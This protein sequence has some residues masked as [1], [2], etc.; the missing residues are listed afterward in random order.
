MN[1]ATFDL[2]LLRVLDAI[3]T[4]G[5][6]VKAGEKLA[7]SQSAV[8][9][10]LSRLRHAL[11]DQLFVRQGN[12]LVPTDFAA[13]LRD[14]LREELD[15]LQAMLTPTV[16]SDPM[17]AEGSFKIS[18]SDFFA[19]MLM[20]ELGSYL[21]KNAPNI[22]AHMV[23]LVPYDYLNSLERYDAD[24]ALIPDTDVPDWINKKPLFKS[25]FLVIGRSEN[26]RLSE[27][28]T[29]DT[30]PLD[31]FCDLHHVLFSPEGKRA[32]FGDT[33]LAEIGRQRRVAMTVPVFSG[34]LRAV[35]VSDLI[36]LV[37]TQLAHKV[38]SEFGLKVLMPPLT[39]PVPLIVAVWHR[40]YDNAPMQKWVREKI[41]D[42][43]Q[44]LDSL[45]FD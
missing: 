11:N 3:L 27:F 9:G 10:A 37:P 18:S 34:V 26:P 12:R 43:M 23:D 2:N 8:S 35:S 30:L 16:A 15:R 7:L 5:S 1:F 13:S 33:A 24:L 22:T 17:I 41:F 32:S 40:R 14:P 36:A 45:T 31:V 29:G 38:A 6:T 25:P 42:L 19:E 39:L 28:E 21:Y 44:P 4:E 20:P